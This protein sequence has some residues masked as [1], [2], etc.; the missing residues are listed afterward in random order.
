MPLRLIDNNTVPPGGVSY[1]QAETRTRLTA[2]SIWYCA[3]IVIKHRVANGIPTSGDR[4]TVMLEIEDQL[5]K[6]MPPNICRDPQG[7]V[8]VSGKDSTL[9]TITRGAATLTDWFINH[10]R[11]KVS[12][13][14]ATERARVCGNCFAN[15]APQ[16]CTPCNYGFI[17]G[18]AAAIVGNDSTPH[19]Q[20]LKACAYCGCLLKQK[21]WLPLKVLLDHTPAEELAEMPPEC[22]MKTEKA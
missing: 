5:C 4:E 10:G 8:K 11:Q 22:W 12:T 19:D 13:E 14:Q 1:W 17:Q 20:S 9:E 18:L 21:I 7:Q 6:T 2:P 16:G 15:K 3:D